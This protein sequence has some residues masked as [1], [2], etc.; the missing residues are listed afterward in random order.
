MLGSSWVAAQLAASQEGLSS[1]SEW[2]MFLSAGS[3]TKLHTKDNR[4][5]VWRK[6]SV[7][8]FLCMGLVIKGSHGDVYEEYCLRGC[9]TVYSGRSLLTFWRKE[10]SQYSAQRTPEANFYQT[11]RCHT[12]KDSVLV[13][14]SNLCPH[15]YLPTSHQTRATGPCSF[16]RYRVP[17]IKWSLHIISAAQFGVFRD[18]HPR[19]RTV[20]K[21]GP[22]DVKM[23][24]NEECRLPGC[25]A[26]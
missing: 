11:T 26:V 25:G 7:W 24:N 8:S 20:R 15:L 2:V 1:M 5:S 10:L 16:S 17:P 9:D 21:M 18:C 13:T 19:V 12:P 3:S 6:E 4:G 14:G 23:N 22:D